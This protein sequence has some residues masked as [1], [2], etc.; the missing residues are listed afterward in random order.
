MGK[1]TKLD[2]WPK[3]ALLYIENT[4]MLWFE[5]AGLWVC[6]LKAKNYCSL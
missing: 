6:I 2:A 3:I 1:G 4:A 5:F